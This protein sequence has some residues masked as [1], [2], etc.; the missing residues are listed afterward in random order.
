MA[1][2]AIRLAIEHRRANNEPIPSRAKALVRE[3]TVVLPA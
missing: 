3:V 2:D 1:E